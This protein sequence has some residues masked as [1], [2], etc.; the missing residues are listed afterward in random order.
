MK[1]STKRR[2]RDLRRETAAQHIHVAIVDRETGMVTSDG[3]KMPYEEYKRRFMLP[4]DEVIY[5][6]AKGTRY[7]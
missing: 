6:T 1:S 7:A 3:Q 4:G 5:V 2:V